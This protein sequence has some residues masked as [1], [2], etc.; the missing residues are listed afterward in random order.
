[1]HT[2]HNDIRLHGAL[3]IVYAYEFKE[4]W[5]QRVQLLLRHVQQLDIRVDICGTACWIIHFH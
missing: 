2:L 3:N 4:D 1:M 5:R